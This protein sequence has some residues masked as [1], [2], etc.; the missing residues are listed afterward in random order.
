[1]IVDPRSSANANSSDKIHRQ[2]TMT[3]VK[4]PFVL[5]DTLSWT[6]ETVFQWV[7]DN[8]IQIVAER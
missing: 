3:E 7:R 4:A 2:I 5:P 6:Q 8:K 1:M